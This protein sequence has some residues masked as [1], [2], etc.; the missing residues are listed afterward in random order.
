MVDDFAGFGHEDIVS[1]N[2]EGLER[3][4][5]GLGE[6]EVFQIDGRRFGRTR[7]RRRRGQDSG[8]D[9]A[10]WRGVSICSGVES[11]EKMLRPVP[12]YS[13]SSL[14]AR[15]S[16]WSVGSRP[17]LVSF[18]ASRARDQRNAGLGGSGRGTSAGRGL[19]G[20]GAR[21]RRGEGAVQLVSAEPKDDSKEGEASRPGACFLF[22]A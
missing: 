22:R 12:S 9:A 1:V 3:F 7:W 2:E 19:D 20:D 5:A 8:L 15:R 18:W 21:R 16:R 10:D 6:A 11:A 4:V 17:S 13:T 14:W